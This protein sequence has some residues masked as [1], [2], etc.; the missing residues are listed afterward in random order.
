MLVSS[1]RRFFLEE[2]GLTATEY[3]IL[4]ALVIVVGVVAARSLGAN[5]AHA[6]Q[7]LDAA[8]GPADLY[9]AEYTS[10]LR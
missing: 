7:A 2:D 10:T 5:T 9:D 1:I 6:F 4:L 8:T 3:A